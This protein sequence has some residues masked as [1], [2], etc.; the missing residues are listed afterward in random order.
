MTSGSSTFSRVPLW[1]ET[2]NVNVDTEGRYSVLMG[3]TLNDG[4][5]LELFTAGEPRW[6]GVQ[7]HR[8]DPTAANHSQ[9][10]PQ[11]LAPDRGKR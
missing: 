5:P 6:L 4:M 8:V 10:Q 2:Q 7:L 9:P 11:P 3:S 1:Q